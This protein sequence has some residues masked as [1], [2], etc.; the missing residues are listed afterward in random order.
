MNMRFPAIYISHG[1]G[2]WPF[3]ET[4]FG[5][6][7]MWAPLEAYL[8]S[9]VSG[10]AARP[11]ALLVVSAHWEAPKVSLMSG[12]H[13]PMLYDYGGF[14][15]E[16]Y[17]IEWPAPGAPALAEQARGLL[18]QAGFATAFDPR[19]GYDHG[20]FVPLKLAVPDADIPVLQISLLSGLDPARHIAMGRALAPLRDEGVFFVGSGSSYHNMRG[21]G[22]PS[23]LKAS[24]VFDDWLAQAVTQAP[25]ARE[26]S[27]VRWAEAPAARECHP[28]EEHLL[29][30]HVMAGAGYA[31]EASIPLRCE[32]L[33]VRV[34][35]V[36]FGG[37]EGS[38]PN[39]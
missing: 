11:R 13:P 31:D 28:R 33:G 26:A 1:G 14:P 9:L 21:F 8:K 4:R 20:T 37:S 38:R 17:H 25:A 32:T 24:Q 23:S 29:P 15:E 6:K 19:R 2:P 30:L 3:V 39:P 36:Q 34:S 27:L 5:S 16:S 10:L 12:D 22:Q 7:E 35:S 18:E